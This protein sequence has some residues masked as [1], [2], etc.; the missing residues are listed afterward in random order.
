MKNYSPVAKNSFDPWPSLIA[1][2]QI[3]LGVCWSVF[4]I[5]YNNLII[6]R[7]YVD[8]IKEYSALLLGDMS[9]QDIIKTF[10]T[11]GIKELGFISEDLANHI[12]GDF[13]SINHSEDNDDYIYLTQDWA[14]L[15][16]SQYRGKRNLFNRFVRFYGDLSASHINI[17]QKSIS[18]ILSLYDLWLYQRVY[19]TEYIKKER[20]LIETIII[21]ADKADISIYGVYDQDKLIACIIYSINR[22]CAFIHF[23]K[24]N[25]NYIG[26]NEYM[27]RQ[28][29]QY[30]LSTG[31]IYINFEEDM[32]DEGLRK[33]KNSWHPYKKIN[34]YSI[35]LLA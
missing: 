32:G 25:K 20:D 12:R 3:A 8:T 26:I 33:Y 30:L 18:D 2:H 21:E 24:V 5:Q 29:A 15:K 14:Q 22:D 7:A 4:Y 9:R 16:P 13:V 27:K 19:L 35:T 11:E 1:Q 28:L 17:N 34:K 31:V 10:H 23:D 6:L